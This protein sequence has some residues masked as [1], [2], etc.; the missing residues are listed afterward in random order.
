MPRSTPAKL[1]PALARCEHER[2]CIASCRALTQHAAGH[3]ALDH[4]GTGADVPAHIVKPCFDLVVRAA[5]L[6]LSRVRRRWAAGRGTLPPTPHLRQPVGDVRHIQACRARVARTRAARSTAEPSAPLTYL[7]PP[8]V[9]TT[10]QV[11][12]ENPA[13]RGT[14]A[15]L[16]TLLTSEVSKRGEDARARACVISEK[17]ER[18]DSSHLGSVAAPGTLRPRASVYG[19]ASVRGT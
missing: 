9:L 4:R 11:I 13:S 15:S 3:V 16:L 19:V 1:E 7:L 10:D 14:E 5:Q 12:R 2:E 18:P 6:H 17:K 8:V